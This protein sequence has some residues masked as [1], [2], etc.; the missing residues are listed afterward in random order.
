[1]LLILAAT[2]SVNEGKGTIAGYFE[3]SALRRLAKTNSSPMHPT[4]ERT[5][6]LTGGFPYP[7]HAA[8]NMNAPRDIGIRTAILIIS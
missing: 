8:M 4:I 1:M 3:T 2:G 7:M 5:C 6:H